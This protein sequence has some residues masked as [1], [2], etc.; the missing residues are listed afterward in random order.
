MKRYL[1]NTLPLNISNKFLKNNEIHGHNT[2][3]HELPHKHRHQSTL[4]LRSILHSATSSYSNIPCH[5][6]DISDEFQF[7]KFLKQYLLC[8]HR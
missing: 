3:Q 7:R 1:N 2:R 5:I 6:R 8:E 4:A